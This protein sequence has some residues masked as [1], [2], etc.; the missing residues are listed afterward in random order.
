MSDPLDVMTPAE[1]HAYLGIGATDTTQDVQLQI[2]VTTISRRLD[3][4]VGP[5]VERTITN[6][7]HRGGGHSVDLNEY[8][9]ASISAVTEYDINGGA[10]ALTAD[11]VSVKNQ[12]GYWL[13]DTVR[14]PR[15]VYRRSSGAADKFPFMGLVEVTYVAGR[16]ADTAHVD[17]LFQ[18]AASL[19]LAKVWRHEQGMPSESF[20]HSQPASGPAAAVGAV[21]DALVHLLAEELLSPGIG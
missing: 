18:Q 15:T 4:L 11:T 8:P 21:P 1:A 16:A 14:R 3:A 10:Q 6:E 5:I 7:H 17:V 2:Y 19:W 13:D 9:V 12:F 20:A